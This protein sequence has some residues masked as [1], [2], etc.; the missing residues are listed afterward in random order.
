MSRGSDKRPAGVHASV[1]Q[2]RTSARAAWWL[3]L[4]F[5][6]AVHAGVIQGVVLEHASGR[7]MARTLVRLDPITGSGAVRQ[8]QSRA[9]RAGHFIFAAVPDGLYLVVAQRQGFFP[10]AH[11]QRRPTGQ[12]TPVEVA[13]DSDLFA[14]LRM[15]RMGAITGRVLDENGIGLPGVSVL[16]YRARLPLR[17]VANGISDDRGVYRIAGLQPG[18]YW[19]RTAAYTLED[20]SGILPTFG[21]LA[22]ESREARVH[23]VKVDAETP[24]AD[25][26]PEA[27][28][29]FQLSGTILCLGGPVTVT[30][31]SETMRRSVQ[32]GC[33]LKYVFEG[34][35]PAAYEVFAAFPDASGSG[36]TELF[37]DR[38]SEAGSVQ[39]TPSPQIEFEVRSAETKNVVRTPVTLAGR[40]DDLSGVESARPIPTPRATLPAGH[41]EFSAIPAPGLYVLAIANTI[42]EFQRRPWRSERPAE[43]HDVF[44]PPRAPARV[45]I[46][47]SDQAARISGATAPGAPVFLWPVSET[48]RRSLGGWR[49]VLADAQ[50]VFR[51]DGLP[52]GEYRLLATFDASEAD[53]D[54]LEEAQA[55]TVTVGVGPNVADLAV[56]NA[57]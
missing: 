52:P 2:E 4:W 25:V 55:R 3:L 11:G 17:P 45:Q 40:R 23:E 9:D 44:L 1:N 51:F 7:P 21:P 50:G 18:K 54:L 39:V 34:L 48:A 10:A 19:V 41:W 13:R 43:S 30:L 8:F 49:Q 14:E 5:A 38:S 33:G 42:R 57:P 15:R 24:D 35:A 46:L 26:R 12:G 56:W 36:F 31:S 20:G 27:G 6:P 47:V 16:A 28:S 22:R 29:L 53:L 32:L 37:L